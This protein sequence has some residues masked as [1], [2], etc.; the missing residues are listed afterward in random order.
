MK[1]FVVGDIHGGYKGLKQCLGRS[2]FDYDKDK[3]I[4]L[5]DICDGWSETPE[6]VD[7]LMKIKKLVYVIGNHDCW[8]MEWFKLGIRP[9]GWEQQGGRATLDAYIKRR[10]ECWKEH[11]K[12][13]KKGHYKY[14]DKKNRIFV[15]GGFYRGVDINFQTWQNLVWDRSLAEK[16]VSGFGSDY[17]RI[18]EY[19]EVYLGHTSVNYFSKKRVPKNL[20]FNSGNVWLMDTGAGME[21][22]LTIMDIDTKEFWQSDN[23]KDLYSGELGRN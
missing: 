11:E 13:F 1:T 4:C 7:E 5:G 12:F 23:L 18:R 9:N 2:S 14:I 21:G 20:P 8:L 22:K 19:N 6:C 15:H 10:Q 16:A 3:L 17:F